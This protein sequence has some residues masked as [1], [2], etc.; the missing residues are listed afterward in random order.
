[1]LSEAGHCI[2]FESFYHSCLLDLAVSG[3]V[4]SW[5][6]GYM[7]QL[8]LGDDSSWD[9]PRMI[10][11]L[12]PNKIGELEFTSQ[13]EDILCHLS[14]YS[15]SSN[16]FPLCAQEGTWSGR[17]SVAALTVVRIKSLT[18]CSP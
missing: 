1:M 18:K 17:S 14:L 13:L 8:G 9:S 15:M 11:S 7:G 6:T 4:F 16:S 5:G 12:D 3:F 2:F 10:R